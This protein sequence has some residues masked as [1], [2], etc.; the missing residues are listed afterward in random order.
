MAKDLSKTKKALAL[1][2]KAFFQ[3]DQ[4]PVN[5]AQLSNKDLDKS[6]IFLESNEE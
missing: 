6:T 1:A 3:K 2:Q 5:L 4:K